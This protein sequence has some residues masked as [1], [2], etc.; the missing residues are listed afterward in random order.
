MTVSCGATSGRF[1]D[2]SGADHGGH[3]NSRSGR[4]GWGGEFRGYGSRDVWGHRATYYGPMIPN[5]FWT[6]TFTSKISAVDG[7]VTRND[8]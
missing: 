1:G 7:T 3:R 8:A 4:S 6:G 2:T 5:I